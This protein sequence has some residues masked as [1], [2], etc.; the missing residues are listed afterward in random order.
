MKSKT[1]TKFLVIMAVLIVA[2]YLLYPT[3]QYNSMTV[4]EQDEM[5]LQNQK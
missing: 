4:D 3:Y 5:L 2:V 1:T